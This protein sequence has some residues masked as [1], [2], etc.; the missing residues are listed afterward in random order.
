MTVKECN[1]L[2]Q[3]NY[4]KKQLKSR[5]ELAKKDATEERKETN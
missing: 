1:V 5:S 4:V 3:V 2:K